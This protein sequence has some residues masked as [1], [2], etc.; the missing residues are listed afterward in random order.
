VVEVF[1][2]VF[3]KRVKKLN[4]LAVVAGAMTILELTR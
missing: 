2:K 3:G 1:Q 4:S